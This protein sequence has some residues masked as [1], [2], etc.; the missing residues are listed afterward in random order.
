MFRVP[1]RPD[2]AEIGQGQSPAWGGGPGI[3]ESVFA[4]VLKDLPQKGINVVN[5]NLRC[6]AVSADKES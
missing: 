1:G 6:R 4:E 5:A 2:R 3:R